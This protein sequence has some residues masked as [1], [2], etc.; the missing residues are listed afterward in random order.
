MYRAPVRPQRSPG[1]PRPTGRFPSP[2]SCWGYPG[3]RS[4]YGGSGPRGGSPH[5]GPAFSP[6]SPAYSPASTRGYRGGSPASTRGYRGGSPAS[7]RGYRDSS[8]VGFGSGSGGQMWRTGGPFPASPV[9]QSLS[10]LPAVQMFRRSGGEIFQSS[11]AAG[12]VGRSAAC[13]SCRHK[14][15]MTGN[16]DAIRQEIKTYGR[17]QTGNQTHPYTTARPLRSS[18]MGL[19]AVPHSRYKHRVGAEVGSVS[20]RDPDNINSPIRYSI[21]RKSDVE[22]YFNID[23]ISG[24]ISTARPL[25]REINAAHNISILATEILDLSQV[26]K[27]VV[28]ISV[29]DINDNAPSLANDYKTFICENAEPGQVIETLSAVDLDDPDNGHHFLFSLSAEAAGNLSFYLRDN[30]DNTASVLTR[31]AGFLQQDQPV[32]FLSVVV[33]DS[34]GLSLSSTN[35]LSV[36]V[37]DCDVH[38]NHRSCNYQ[39]SPQHVGFST[40]ATVTVLTCILT[41][42]CVVM[43]TL[44]VRHRGRERLMTDSEREV[45][46]NIVRY[47]DEGGGEEDTEAYDMFTLRT[48]NQTNQARHDTDMTMPRLVTPEDSADRNL[49]QVL[50]RDRLQEADLDKTA[51]PYDSLQTYAFEGSGSAADSLSSLNS[52]NSLESEHNY[53]FLRVWGPR[54]KKL[55]D[56]YGPHEVGG[57]PRCPQIREKQ[58]FRQRV[59]WDH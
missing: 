45:R 50:I 1:A 8:P 25:D 40:A 29:T 14:D 35:T 55:A 7:T 44:A 56:L 32:H 12:P 2:A 26:G 4:P 52:L 49:F 41:V 34:G 36:T 39:E 27:S 19:L 5:G 31:R 13:H 16:K 46:E 22:C 20:A 21:D 15:A 10:S 6:G 51:P 53:D 37:C 17:H 48:L 11:D 59:T 18:N 24:V 3:A 42:L 28:L 23:S 58:P 9:L 30:E 43:V 33:S 54:F 38:G 47:D 57:L